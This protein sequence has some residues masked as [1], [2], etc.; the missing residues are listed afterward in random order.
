MRL[1]VETAVFA[2]VFVRRYIL[3]LVVLYEFKKIWK[4]SEKSFVKK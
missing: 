1:N 2:E 4:C 3:R